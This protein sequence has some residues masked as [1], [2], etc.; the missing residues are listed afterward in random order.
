MIQQKTYAKYFY[1]NK[2][3]FDIVGRSLQKDFQFKMD[4]LVLPKSV[5]PLTVNYQFKR[6][7]IKEHYFRA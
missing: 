7:T 3:M 4:V 6:Q 2:N 5:N 1:V